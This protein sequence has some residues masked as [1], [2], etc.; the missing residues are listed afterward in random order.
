[1]LNNWLL[2]H[3]AEKADTWA[4]H[5][6]FCMLD[7]VTEHVAA[8]KHSSSRQV[9]R[10]QT[11]QTVALNGCIQLDLISLDHHSVNNGLHVQQEDRLHPDALY[12]F[13]KIPNDMLN[14][15][16]NFPSHKISNKNFPSHKISNKIKHQ[17]LYA[18]EG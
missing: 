15:Q 6:S 17:D 5:P 12:I 2:S 13:E 1:M 11:V 4:T 10:Q 9:T 16:F 8:K 14:W 3:T 18:E 7:F